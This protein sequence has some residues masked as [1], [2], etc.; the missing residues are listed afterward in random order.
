MAEKAEKAERQNGEKGG[1]AEKVNCI[2]Q[3]WTWIR[4]D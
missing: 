1:T 3:K 4:I 2:F